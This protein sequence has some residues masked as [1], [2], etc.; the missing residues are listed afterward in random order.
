ME[1]ENYVFANTSAYLFF[2]LNIILLDFFDGLT[3]VFLE[4]V[5]KRETSSSWL[6]PWLLTLASQHHPF[7]FFWF[8][9]KSLFGILFEEGE[10]YVFA[11]TSAFLIWVTDT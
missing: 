7:G 9:R 2:F 4:G 11:N 8:P 6:T 5:L 10:N 1:G 3:K